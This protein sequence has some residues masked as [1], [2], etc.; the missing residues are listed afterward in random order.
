MQT[1]QI[2]ENLNSTTV[3]NTLTSAQ[4]AEVIRVGGGVHG[5]ACYKQAIINLRGEKDK[6]KQDDI[7][8]YHIPAFIPSVNYPGNSRATGETYEHLPYMM[9]DV[10]GK[11]NPHLAKTGAAFTALLPGELVFMSPRGDGGRKMLIPVVL[12]NQFDYPAAYQHLTA[13]VNT[14][15]QKRGK[16]PVKFDDKAALITQTC[17][18]S[19]DKNVQH[20]D[21]MATVTPPYGAVKSKPTR[22]ANSVLSEADWLNVDTSSVSGLFNSTV[23]KLAAAG[24][25][26]GKSSTYGFLLEIVRLKLHGVTSPELVNLVHQHAAGKYTSKHR[27][28]VVTKR[29][30]KLYSELFA[31]VEQPATAEPV[32]GNLYEFDQYLTEH[33]DAVW[34]QLQQHQTLF[35]DAPTGAGKT[36]LIRELAKLSGLTLDL[37]CPTTAL[38]QQQPTHLTGAGML[39]AEHYTAPVLACCYESVAKVRKRQADVLVID[40]AHE[41]ASAY[42][43]R[44]EAIQTIAEYAAGYKHVIYLSG[45]M[46]PLASDKNM[47]NLLKFRRKIAK[48]VPFDI[49]TLGKREKDTDYFAST[50]RSNVLNVFYK[51]NKAQLAA[52]EQYL[53]TRGLRVLLVSAD[54]KEDDGYR[55]MIA[56]ETLRG[57]DVVLTT[58]M[59]QS[60]VNVIDTRPVHIVFGLGA[61]VLDY[62]QFSARFRAITPTVEIVHSG[63][64]GALFGFNEQ[65]TRQ[66]IEATIAGLNQAKKINNDL[67]INQKSFFKPSTIDGTCLDGHGQYEVDDYYLLHKK[68][69]VL[70]TN[71]NNNVLFLRTVLAA[72][73][74]SAPS[75]QESPFIAAPA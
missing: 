68:N 30:T 71:A 51:N 56:E 44:S 63:K 52:L 33:L 72:R 25:V 18:L 1:F 49:V 23:T 11:D 28:D 40:E 27:K 21:E 47:I 13:V 10:D 60:G 45:S 70:N 29:L 12:R 55:A 73:A 5:V 31:N 34:Q 67:K 8:R 35:I 2:I 24:T 62:I 41:L 75:S 54:T 61:N 19:W 48:P 3:T 38:A 64:V 16:A 42:N 20:G 9:L 36:T 43:Y 53:S 58:C 22:G 46:F 14:L 15:L 59:L 7:K 65:I 32:A 50:L 66:Q 6:A 74:R 39:E 26:W 69:E 57:Y 17:L 37:L 4:L